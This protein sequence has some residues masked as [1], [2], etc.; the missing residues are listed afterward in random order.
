MVVQKLTA[1]TVLII[2]I[3]VIFFFGI[4]LYTLAR[5]QPYLSGP[6][7][8]VI[9]PRNGET[10]NDAVVFVEGYVE[11]VDTL[12]LNDRPIY[13]D[14]AGYF[15]EALPIPYG[16]SIIELTASDRFGR[17]IT[18]LRKLVRTHEKNNDKNEETAG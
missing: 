1:K 7:I 15:K 18:Q 8:Q 2:A 17:T 3:S 14:S 9:R 16:Y 10:I 4:L 12:T 13:R 6:H 11:R 5:A